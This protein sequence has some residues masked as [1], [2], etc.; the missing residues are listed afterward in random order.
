[1]LPINKSNIRPHKIITTLILLT[2]ILFLNSCA[3]RTPVRENQYELSWSDEFNN[4]A[5]DTTIWKKMKRVKNVRSFMHFTHDERFYNLNNGRLRLYA[6]YN[7]NY[8][9]TDTAKYLTG[10]I[11]S[12]GKAH[13]KYG[14]IEVRVKFKGARGTW[15][16]IW[17]LPI[18]K[19]YRSTKNPYYTE[20]DI[21]EYVDNND[22]AYQTIHNGYTL[23]N[24]KNWYKPLHHATTDIKLG[25]YNIYSVEI[26]QNEV[27]FRINGKETL[28]YPRL[29]HIEHQ[30]YYGIES[31]LMLHMQVNPPKSWSKGVDPTTFPAYMDIDWVRVYKLKE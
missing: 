22:F 7:E 31:F 17:T 29:K 15:P 30:F 11:S 1:M 20:I 26:L 27:I 21:V 19:Q 6:R 8:I 3:I 10:G 12:E 16:A 24:Q 25:K 5:L 14:K 13:F 2:L 9:P 18:N 4:S 28:R 23:Q